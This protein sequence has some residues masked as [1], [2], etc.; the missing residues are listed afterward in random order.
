MASFQA[1][2]WEGR[3]GS[4]EGCLVFSKDQVD[5]RG[6]RADGG[7]VEVPEEVGEGGIGVM[8]VG[9]MRPVHHLRMRDRSGQAWGPSHQSHLPLPP[10]GLQRAGRGAGGAPGRGCVGGDPRCE[11]QFCHP[12]V[13]SFP[14]PSHCLCHRRRPVLGAVGSLGGSGPAGTHFS[15]LP[16]VPAHL[17]AAPARFLTIGRSVAGLQTQVR[18]PL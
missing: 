17:E 5:S 6:S 15:V 2:C 13:Q 14:L 11:P 1:V 9:F 3:I 8:G 16:G 18:S 12:L 4:W 7:A 10:W